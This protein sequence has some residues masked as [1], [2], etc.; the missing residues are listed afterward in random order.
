MDMT[1]KTT[2]GIAVV[3][4]QTDEAKRYLKGRYDV[5]EGRAVA[6]NEEMLMPF[7][8]QAMAAGLNLQAEGA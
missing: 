8:V 7:S 1:F 6:M 4:P 2:N 3:T 5:A